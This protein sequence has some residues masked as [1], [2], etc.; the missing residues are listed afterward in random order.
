MGFRFLTLF[1]MKFKKFVKH[2][3]DGVDIYRNENNPKHCMI[4]AYVALSVINY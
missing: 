2:I 3:T 4:Y 1:I